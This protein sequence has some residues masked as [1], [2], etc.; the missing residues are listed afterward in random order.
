MDENYFFLN[1]R[2]HPW[3]KMLSVDEEMSSMDNSFTPHCYPW[4]KS[5][6]KGDRTIDYVKNLLLK[7]IYMYSFCSVCSIHYN[8]IGKLDSESD[9]IKVHTVL[10]EWKITSTVCSEIAFF[11]ESMAEDKVL[12]HLSSC[13]SKW[14]FRHPSKADASNSL[15]LGGGRRWRRH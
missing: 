6:D 8:F 4:M 12:P 15:I 7:N 3:Q 13:S 10:F 11:Q 14:I 9:D 2:N 1:Q 5:T